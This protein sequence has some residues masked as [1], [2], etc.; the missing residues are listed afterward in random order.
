[1]QYDG[2]GQMTGVT[3]WLGNT[4][5]FQ[6]DSGG[7]VYDSS[8]TYT[9]G[10][11]TVRTRPVPDAANQILHITNRDAN[12]IS[13]RHLRLHPRRGRAD[14]R[15]SQHRSGPARQSYS[16]DAKGR[17]GSEN[18]HRLTFDSRNNLPRSSPTDQRS[19]TTR[20]DQPV[21]MAM[22]TDPHRSFTY[23]A[24]GQRTSSSSADSR[25]R[26]RLGRCRRPDLVSAGG[27]TATYTSNGD[28]LRNQPGAGGTSHVFVWSLHRTSVRLGWPSNRLRRRAQGHVRR[29]PRHPEIALGGD[30]RLA[31]PLL[32]GVL[33]PVRLRPSSATAPTASSTAPTG[34]R[35]SRSTM[36]ATRCSWTRTPRAACGS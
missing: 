18:G 4:T 14:H 21:S 23:D 29:G 32:A 16:Y 36:P 30:S 19:A 7:K 22:R 17:L 6:Y 25:P 26:L 12:G 33:K 10:D 3:D 31:Q 34:C 20:R 9:D 27:T 28:G 8:K 13:V 35:S 5:Q 11:T 1:M 24:N 2:D 15:G